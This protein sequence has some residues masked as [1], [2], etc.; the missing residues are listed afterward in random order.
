MARRHHRRR[1]MLLPACEAGGKRRRVTHVSGASKGQRWGAGVVALAL[2]GGA[3]WMLRQMDFRRLAE[4]IADLRWPWLAVVALLYLAS[5]WL[6]AWRWGLLLPKRVDFGA[7]LGASFGGFMV[8]FVMPLRAGELARAWMIGRWGGLRF[9]PALGSLVVERVL[10]AVTVI[11][12]LA[13]VV[14]GAEAVPDWLA[15]G[16][17]GLGVMA[18][19]GIVGL[20]AVYVLRKTFERW[21]ASWFPTGPGSPKWRAALGHL[22]GGILEGVGAVRSPGRWLLAVG[23]TLGVWGIFAGMYAAGLPMMGLDA[24]PQAGLAVMVL[25]ALAV[26]APGPPG[27]LGTF[28]AG[29]IAALALYGVGKEEALGYSLVMHAVQA[30]ILLPAGWWAMRSHHMKWSEAKAVVAEER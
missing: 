8:A 13:W 5:F 24:P 3:V 23:G 12:A 19:A 26:A 16:A 20:A 30:A 21:C 27:F 4:A 18:L 2:V 1:A 15:A 22:A 10:D 28:Q 7:R 6:R 14:A 29:C 25:V 11:G 9:A 17:R